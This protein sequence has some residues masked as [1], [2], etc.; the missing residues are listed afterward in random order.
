MENNMKILV[1]AG[2]VRTGS[3]NMALANQTVLAL[4]KRTL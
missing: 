3:Y 2:S 1:I 4:E